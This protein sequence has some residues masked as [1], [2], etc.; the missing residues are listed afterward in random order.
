MKTSFRRTLI[1]LWAGVLAMIVFYPK[2]VFGQ[3]FTPFGGENA[4]ILEMVLRVT[5]LTAVLFAAIA[6][7]RSVIGILLG[8]WAVIP[9]IAFTI[10]GWNV[11]LTPFAFVGILSLVTMKWQLSHYP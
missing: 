4:M 2:V 6:L 11:A 5:S 7:R 10:T 8:S 1:V 9:I 3:L